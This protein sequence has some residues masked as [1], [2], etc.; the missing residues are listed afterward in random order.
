MLTCSLYFATQF[1]LQILNTNIIKY[2][3]EAIFT[4]YN[5]VEEQT[6]QSPCLGSGNHNICE[7]GKWER[8]CA[9]R[10][11]PLHTVIFI[12]GI[13]R[14]EILDRTSIKNGKTINIFYNKDIKA[15][16]KFGKKTLRY[17]ICN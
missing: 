1:C 6:D 9:S 7:I 8:V 4:A 12:E 17:N 14:C 15:A 13:G 16:L 5:S 3:Q 10:L 2:D 11:Y